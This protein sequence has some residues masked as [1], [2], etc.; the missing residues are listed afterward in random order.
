MNKNTAPSFTSLL[1]LQQEK[2]DSLL[3]RLDRKRPSSTTISA[4]PIPEPPKRSKAEVNF[5]YQ[6]QDLSIKQE[7][8]PLCVTIQDE[9]D[10]LRPA[11]LAT[12]VR[13]ESSSSDIM[14]ALENGQ[15]L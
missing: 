8:Q 1:L 9:D 6:M 5:Q 4:M 3:S 13:G 11:V 12:N 15:N 7:T 2:F 10:I 14:E